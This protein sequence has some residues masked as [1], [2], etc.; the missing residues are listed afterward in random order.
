MGKFLDAEK[1]SNN[2]D[3]WLKLHDYEI[4]DNIKKIYAKSYVLNGQA[5]NISIELRDEI[6]NIEVENRTKNIRFK[7]LHR[8]ECWI[9]DFWVSGFLDALDVEVEKMIG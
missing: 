6:V 9:Y 4:V 8:Y 5:V 2:L 3:R 1:E 7:E